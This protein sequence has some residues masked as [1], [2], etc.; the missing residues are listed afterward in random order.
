[1]SVDFAGRLATEIQKNYESK[2]FPRARAFRNALCSILEDD[3]ELVP[4]RSGDI[5]GYAL[6]GLP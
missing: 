2:Q 5:A 4:E 1:M 6:W 3:I